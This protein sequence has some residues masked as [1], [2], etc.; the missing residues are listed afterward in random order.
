LK[1]Q[2]KVTKAAEIEKQLSGLFEEI[3]QRRSVEL[4]A[5][6]SFI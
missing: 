3:E 1:K 2:N 5:K 4:H 6:P